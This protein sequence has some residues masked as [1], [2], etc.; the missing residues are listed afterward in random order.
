VTRLVCV[1]RWSSSNV[2][3]PSLFDLVDADGIRIHGQVIAEQSGDIVLYALIVPR[4][5]NNVWGKIRV[6]DVQY[7]RIATVAIR[8]IKTSQR[9]SGSRVAACP[10]EEATVAI[11]TV[12]SRNA[13]PG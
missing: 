10:V 11:G 4:L 1:T 2:C 5:P 8:Q 3:A 13:Q 12:G 7:L 9:L 6:V